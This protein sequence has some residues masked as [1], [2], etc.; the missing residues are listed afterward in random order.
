MLDLLQD[1]GLQLLQGVL[2]AAV[3]IV[4]GFVA[5]WLRSQ[6]A[7]QKAKLSAQQISIIN[8]IVSIA[9][10]AAEQLGL[11]EAIDDRKDYALAYAQ[12]YLNLHNI[13]LDINL[14]SVA[15]EAAVL[16]EFNWD[17][18][19]PDITITSGPK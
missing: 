6:V 7:L 17:K 4:V 19:I 10:N 11:A 2:I 5:Q 9:I 18:L 16:S 13:K 3:P 8:Q 15:I 1:F 12:E 14:I